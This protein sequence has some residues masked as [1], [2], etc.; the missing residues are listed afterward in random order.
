MPVTNAFPRSDG[1][2]C[3]QCRS[4]LIH[5]EHQG[6]DC[7]REFY[8]FM[9]LDVLAEVPGRAD[10]GNRL[11]WLLIKYMKAWDSTLVHPGNVVLPVN[12]LICCFNIPLFLFICPDACGF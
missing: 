11:N 6:N 8:V 1:A 5:V 2:W 7:P 12:N 9:V 3:S 10:G 4:T